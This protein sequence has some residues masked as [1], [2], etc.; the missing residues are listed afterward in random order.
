MSPTRLHNASK[1]N[2]LSRRAIYEERNQTC[3]EKF[4]ERANEDSYF[5][6]KEHELIENMRIEFH[7]VQA[8][9][10]DAAMATCPKCSGK[11]RKY[12]LL[13]FCS[14][15]V[16]TARESGSTR[17]SSTASCGSRRAV[18]WRFSSIV[19]SPRLKQTIR[20]SATRRHL[21]RDGHAG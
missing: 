20:A 17:A 16:K 9:R 15:A 8:A 13:G 21:E 3:Q 19:V 1:R 5:A 11:F 2:N 6:A 4:D 14:T 12:P 7:K 18:R 10:R